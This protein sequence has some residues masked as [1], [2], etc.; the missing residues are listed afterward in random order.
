M[1]V[2]MNSWHY[3]LNGFYNSGYTPT[4]LC[5]YFWN[6]VAVVILTVLLCTLALA[7]AGASIALIVL[8]AYGSYLTVADSP[9]IQWILG[10]IGSVVVVGIGVR[11][12]VTGNN[13]IGTAWKHRPHP[14]EAL[15]G[16]YVSA[17]KRRVCPLIELED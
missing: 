16:Q 4:N 5:S 10:S 8:G 15:A 7:L 13:I 2:S 17:K 3:K 1:K 12:L 14:T 9:V 6:T 11:Y